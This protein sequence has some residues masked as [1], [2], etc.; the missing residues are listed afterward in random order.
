MLLAFGDEGAHFAGLRLLAAS[1]FKSAPAMKIDFFAEVIISPR[2][3]ASFSIASTCSAQ[4]LERGG[5]RKCS[6]PIPADRRSGCRFDRL[7]LRGESWNRSRLPSSGLILAAFARMP[8]GE[9]DGVMR[10]RVIRLGLPVGVASSQ[11]SA[12]PIGMTRQRRLADDCAGCRADVRTRRHRFG[13]ASRLWSARFLLPEIK[14][15]IEARDF[16]ALA[17]AL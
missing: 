10:G 17:R 5:D 8:S 3:D 15:L 16:D 4:I 9:R 1:V 11:I 6:R 2:S 7:R 14:S 12:S 13:A